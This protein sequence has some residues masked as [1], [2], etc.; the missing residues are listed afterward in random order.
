V[1]FLDSQV[2]GYVVSVSHG[3][4]KLSGAPFSTAP[5]G[6]AI[7]KGSGLTYPILN[8][9]K[10]LMANGTYMRI[11]DKWGVQNGAITNPV[12]NGATS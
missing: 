10:A 9:V 1:G 4:F 12:V 7:P 2:A 6:F 8:A 11:L 3:Q 5:Y